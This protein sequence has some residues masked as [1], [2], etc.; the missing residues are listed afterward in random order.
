MKKLQHKKQRSN[1]SLGLFVSLLMIV[2]SIGS[3]N[4]QNFGYIHRD[5]ILKSVPNYL[6]KLQ[7]LSDNQKKYSAEISQGMENLQQK[8][9]KLLQ[10][11]KHTEKENLVGIKARMNPID[12]VK[13]NLLLD[14]EKSLIKKEESYNYMLNFTYKNEKQ[15]ILDKVNQAINSYA[16]KNKYDGIY[17]LENVS[18]ALAYINEDKIITQAIIDLV[19]NQKNG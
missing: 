19:K 10:P 8:V 14:E 7:E 13:L 1:P 11:Y 18:S 16:K 4:A 3:V 17:I 5:S 2:A 9:S 6:P 15:P 12:T